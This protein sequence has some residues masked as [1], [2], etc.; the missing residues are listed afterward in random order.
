MNSRTS[1]AFML[2]SD[3]LQSSVLEE[4][5]V[6]GVVCF[7]PLLSVLAAQRVTK[8]RGGLF[9]LIPAGIAYGQNST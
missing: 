4:T 6:L 5:L 2:E 8:V 9:T 3:N 1:A 7:G